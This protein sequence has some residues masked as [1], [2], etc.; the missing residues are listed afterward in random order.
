MDLE[1]YKTKN[2]LKK[3]CESSKQNLINLLTNT[4]IIQ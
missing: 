1:L 4:D 3:F 2:I